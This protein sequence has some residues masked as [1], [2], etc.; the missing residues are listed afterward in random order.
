[1]TLSVDAL[2]LDVQMS[3][4]GYDI[5][6]HDA[7]IN[8]LT[9]GQGNVL[10]LDFASLRGLNAA[11]N[12]RDGWSEPQQIPTLHEVL[13][14]ARPYEVQVFI[15]LKPSERNKGQYGSYPG[16]VEA[17]LKAMQD[18]NMLARCMVMSFDWSLLP[19]MKELAPEVP[20]GALVSTHQWDALAP[21][22]LSKL[23][24]RV[25][26]LQCAWVHLDNRLFSPEIPGFLHQN[27][28][29]LGIWTVNDVNRMKTLV[30]AGVDA[31]TS[32]YPDLFPA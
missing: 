32:D 23:V 4:D 9:N 11:A 15:E 7:T 20:T 22:G 17:T 10:D 26:A 21:G 28:L 3:N 2:E 6:F 8:R 1:L 29:L 25:Q 19:K 27:D 18:T 16:I 31:M 24:E 30:A 12:F 13:E 5:V 14:L